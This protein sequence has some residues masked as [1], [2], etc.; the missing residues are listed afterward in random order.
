MCAVKSTHRRVPT[1]FYPSFDEA[2]TI[3][4]VGT[5]PHILPCGLSCLDYFRGRKVGKWKRIRELCPKDIG[6]INKNVRGRRG[7]KKTVGENAGIVFC[8]GFP[9]PV[10]RSACKSVCAFF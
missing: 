5:V 3:R 10:I 6:K 7:M 8:F 1:I 2:T 4:L 9:L